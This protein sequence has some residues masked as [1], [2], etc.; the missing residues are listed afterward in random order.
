MNFHIT[1]LIA[2]LVGLVLSLIGIGIL[3]LALRIVTKW[4]RGDFR[5][6]R[7]PHARPGGP[8]LDIGTDNAANIQSMA[9][10][11]KQ[12]GA[13]LRQYDPELR[14]QIEWEPWSLLIVNLI[15]SKS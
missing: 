11:A 10:S 12:F 14:K 1:L 5:A 3:I 13:F 15:V 6:G 4:V 9:T 7:H 2:S 8:V